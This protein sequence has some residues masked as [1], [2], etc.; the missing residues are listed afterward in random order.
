MAVLAFGFL[1][2]I[3]GSGQAAQSPIQHLI[4]IVLENHSFDNYFGTYPGANDF[5]AKLSISVNPGMASLGSI[6]P[7]H[8]RA[9]V[10]F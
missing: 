9:D 3:N 8:L 10:P 7:Y 6:S 4:F 2:P 5:P 1:S